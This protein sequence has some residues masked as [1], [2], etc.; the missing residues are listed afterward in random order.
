MISIESLFYKKSPIELYLQNEN[1]FL[2]IKRED[3]NFASF[4][5]KLKKWKGL[6]D[7]LTKNKIQTVLIY[8]NPHS[9]FLA[10]YTYLLKLAKKIIY[11]IHYTKDPNLITANSILS[12]RFSDVVI[13]SKSKQNREFYINEF[14]KKNPEGFIIPEF[15]IHE[16]SLSSLKDY[17]K[18][19]ELEFS[20][21]LLFLDI[22]TGFSILSAI[23]SLPNKKIIGI[24]IGNQY[25]KIKN[26]LLQYSNQLFLDKKNIDKIEVLKVNCS[27]AFSSTNQELDDFI[28]WNWQEKNLP[29]EPVYSA[30]TIYTILD[31]LK[32]KKLEGRALYVHQGGLL[33]HLK[34]FK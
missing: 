4:G 25:D 30:K 5:L 19:L 29:L 7:F 11:S 10:T 34:Y 2:Y 9:N 16:S 27:P 14:K 21:D 31:Y 33:N 26:D 8:G 3:K 15:G 18:R 1:F 6:N 17:W 13:Q 23:D 24:S 20:F 32:K 12:K 28:K 22:G